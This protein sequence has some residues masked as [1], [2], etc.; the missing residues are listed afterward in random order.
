MSRILSSPSRGVLLAAA[1]ALP[2]SSHATQLI[3]VFAMGDSLALGSEAAAREY[4]RDYYGYGTEPGN[5]SNPGSGA[6]NPVGFVGWRAQ[7]QFHLADAGFEVDMVGNVSSV[8]NIPDTILNGSLNPAQFTTADNRTYAYDPDNTSGAGWRIGGL[9]DLSKLTGSQTLANLHGNTGFGGYVYT[10]GQLPISTYDNTAPI[11]I[12]GPGVDVIDTDG[13]GLFSE[14]APANV[15]D[16]G[17]ADHLPEMAV[18]LSQANAIVIQIGVNDLKNREDVEGSGS[19]VAERVENGN[20]QARLYNMILQIRSMV[21]NST[22][23][24]VANIAT[25]N[26]EFRW[27]TTADAQEAIE[28]FNE[29]FRTTYFGNDFQD[30]A[31]YDDAIAS[32]SALADP[33]GLLDNVFLVNIHGQI[34]QL[35][36]LGGSPLT[37][38]GASAQ[39]S[40]DYSIALSSDN[41]HW[42]QAGYD[43]VGEFFGKVIAA[44][45]SVPEPSS[46]GLLAAAGLM[47]VRR[48]RGA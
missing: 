25:V 6:Y 43:H 35:I 30:L 27:D 12:T 26:E 44:N 9:Y 1:L 33:L 48:R 37:D 4:V 42:T 22:E 29:S 17:L 36:G 31:G 18:P 14:S 20:A 24:Y 45:T 3:N 8:S 46:A 13:N 28:A 2:V 19:S 10:P 40:P 41:L 47:M 11:D 34:D 38:P 39:S 5:S 21:S 7:L 16:R 15:F 32:A 23:I